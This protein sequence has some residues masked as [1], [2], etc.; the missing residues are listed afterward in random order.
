MPEET[1]ASNATLKDTESI[2]EYNPNSYQSVLVKIIGCTSV[3]PSHITDAFEG[4]TTLLKRG[5]QD[6][7]LTGAEIRVYT[8]NV[9][10]SNT[11]GTESFQKQAD[12]YV[13]QS[14]DD[15]GADLHS[16]GGANLWVT[17]ERTTAHPVD[18]S[19]SVY[20]PQYSYGRNSSYPHAWGESKFACTHE[21]G[22]LLVNTT[23]DL[24][25][26]RESLT[27]NPFNYGCADGDYCHRDHTLATTVETAGSIG[28]TIM[29][30]P[31]NEREHGLGDCASD[32]IG[33]HQ[34][35]YGSECFHTALDNT[36]RWSEH[37][38]T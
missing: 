35:Y 13:D 5:V 15:A 37:G 24:P 21:L 11:D 25:E 17:T 26:N 4:I 32:R 19:P 6:T 20:S 8:S 34:L 14:R 27:A 33:D 10:F 28:V 3:S 29:S 38:E 31:D 9:D 36:V 22:H 12:R 2:G 18:Y 30:R 16:P 1:S 23:E 7:E